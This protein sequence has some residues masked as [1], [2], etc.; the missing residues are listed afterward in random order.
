MRGFCFIIYQRGTG[1]CV[2]RKIAYGRKTKVDRP[3]AILLLYIFILKVNRLILFLTN[4]KVKIMNKPFRILS[5]SGGGIRGIFQAHF[6]E[7]MSSILPQPLHQSFDLICGTSTGSIVGLAIANGVD[8]SL[9]RN[10][11]KEK[12]ESIFKKS[13]FAPINKGPIYDTEVL[14]RELV[15][16]FGNKQLKDSKTKVLITSSSISNYD[17][18]VFANFSTHTGQDSNLS[19]V[20]VILSSSAAPTYFIPHQPTGQERHYVDGGLWANTPSSLAILYTNKYLKIPLS[21]IRLVSIGTGDFPNGATIEHFKKLRRFSLKAIET[22]FEL[23][24]SSQSSFADLYS[25]E[26][27]GDTN[28]LRVSTNLE[29]P[30]ALDDVKKA[31]ANLPSKAEQAAEVYSTKFKSLLEHHITKD[32]IIQNWDRDQLISDYLVKETGLTAFYPSRDY[33][34][35]RAGADTIHTYVDTAKEKLIMVSISLIR[36]INFDD[37]RTVLERKLENRS[38]GF[39][40]TISFLNPNKDYLMESLC[41]VFEKEKEDIIKDIKDGIALIQKFKNK[42]SLYAQKRLTLKLHNSIPFGSAII[43][44]YDKPY[45]KIQ[46]ETKAYKVPMGKSFAFEVVPHKK[47]GYYDTMLEGYLNLINDGQSI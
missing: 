26:V 22:V 38:N 29:E 28:Y 43:M 34:K 45:G 17:H 39:E 8:L 9:I 14:K 11:Y 46:I 27:L 32:I 21:D 3:Y 13:S 19:L 30:I 4:S 42:L 24:F 25:R 36:G 35:L 20:D 31:I 18:K 10:L 7:K 15:T 16:I 1:K 5:L 40:A 12:G 2:P 6:L 44:D 37:L 41:S 47:N 23:M 33:Y